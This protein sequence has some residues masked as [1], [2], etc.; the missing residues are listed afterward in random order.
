VP[1][2][3]YVHT[4]PHHDDIMLGTRRWA[5]RASNATITRDLS[6]T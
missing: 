6:F 4:A 2:R 1:G 5:H 3:S